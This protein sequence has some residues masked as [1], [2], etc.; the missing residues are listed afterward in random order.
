M[1]NFIKSFTPTPAV[2]SPAENSSLEFSVV[3]DV[4]SC[5]RERERERAIQ[6]LVK[7]FMLLSILKIIS[8]LSFLESGLKMAFLTVVLFGKWFCQF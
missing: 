3:G 8:L 1:V 5:D 6:N 4:M 2:R 7:Y